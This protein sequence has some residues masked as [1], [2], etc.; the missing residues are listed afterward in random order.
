MEPS[1]YALLTDQYELT[2]LQA[3]WT[4]KLTEGSVFSLFIRNLPRTRNFL[5]ACG[6][7][8]AM[9]YLENLRF[10]GGDI[11]YLRRN[12]L[13]TPAFLEWLR[14]FTF[15]GNVYAVP[16]GTPIFGQEPILEVE[17]SLPEAQLVETFLLNQ[18]HHQTLLA[19]KAVR[20]VLAAGDRS[21]MDFG[22]RRMHGIDAAIKSS[23]IFHIAGVKAT[24]HVLGGKVYGVPI[25]GT[26]AH[27]Y[28]QAHD[29]EE[30]AFQAFSNLYP[31]TI[32]LVDTYDTL[33]GVKRVIEMIKS[34]HLSTRIRGVRLDSGDLVKLAFDARK[35]LDEAGLNHVGIFA[36]GGLDEWEIKKMVDAQA[37]II[38]FGVGTRMGVSEDA[39]SCDAVYKLTEYDGKGRLKASSGKELLPGR[40][41]VFR[42]LEQ[43]VAVRDILCAE[44]EHHEGRA[45]LEKV[46]ENGKR[47]K[48]AESL[49]A[50]RDRL[51]RELGILPRKIL[52]VD[53][54][55]PPY[56]VSL[57]KRLKEK[58]EA[59][60]QANE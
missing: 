5:V 59:L 24:S 31:E 6:L 36:S 49:D 12:E 44:G 11:D 42:Q 32:L 35:M 9:E 55:D 30:N 46:M 14:E 38:G 21:V 27:S 37:P 51:R 41:Q 17:A 3:Y 60:L 50:I 48:E 39:P 15:H 19:S 56:D 57:S 18:V 4:E 52:G 29:S 34:G 7:H 10:T 45:L 43:G 47:L 22:V 8:D 25:A 23:R 1:S 13:F 26:M 53:H 2:M 16:E 20:V 58:Q 28:I 40:K 54:A 33:R